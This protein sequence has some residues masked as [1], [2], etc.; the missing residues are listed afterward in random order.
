MIQPETRVTRSSNSAWIL[1]KIF[2]VY[3]SGLRHRGHASFIALGAIKKRQYIDPNKRRHQIARTAYNCITST[4]QPNR[5]LDGQIMR[6]KYNK[7][8]TIT[9][10][11][12]RSRLKMRNL[13]FFNTRRPKYLKHAPT[14]I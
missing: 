6:A 11:I 12:R 14:F 1:L 3:N 5:W 9:Q 10:R 4:I 13:I 8:A 2:H 7:S